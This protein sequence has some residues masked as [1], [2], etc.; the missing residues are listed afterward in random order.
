MLNYMRDSLKHGS[1]PKLVL[2][3]VAIGLVAYLGAY[4]SCE[5][6]PRQGG[7]WA[8]SINGTEIPT[9]LFLTT[10]RNID[11]RYREMFG[12]NYEQF[13]QQAQIGTQAIQMLVERELVLQDA[14]RLGLAV[15][16]EELVERIRG[17]EGLQDP[18]T[19]QFVGKQRYVQAVSRL[20]P[21]GVAAFEQDL[22]NEILMDKW[23]DLVTQT[24]AVSDDELLELYR[25]RTERTAVNYA[26]V[27]SADQ[28]YETELDDTE[29]ARWYD[30]H[31]DDYMRDEGR[32]IRFVVLERQALADRIE[33]TDEEVRASYE[34]NQ[35]NYSHP[36]QRRASHI[37]I[38]TEP[39]AAEEEK[40]RLRRVAEGLMTRALAGEDFAE[41]ARANSQDPGSAERGGDLDFFSRGQMVPP[42]E[43][44]AFNTPVGQIAPLVES[45]FGFHIIKVTDAREAGVTPLD[46]VADQIRRTLRL[47]RA[48]EEVVSEAQR[49]RAELQEAAGLEEVAAREGLEVQ[50]RFLTREDRLTDLGASPEFAQTV[51]DLETGGISPPLRTAPG[52]A[53][54]VVDEIVPASVAPL[55]EIRNS[56]GTDILN[57]RA[58]QAALAAASRALERHGDLAAAARALGEEVKESG[59][60]APGGT[61]PGTGGSTPEMEE[62]L[63][64]PGVMEGDRGV[65]AVPAGALVYEVTARV[66][67]DSLAYEDA[68]ADL[69][70]EL[71]EQRRSA[72]YR[73]VL[74]RMYQQ[75]E[76][77]IN[78]E[79]VEAYNG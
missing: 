61:I 24:V 21:G 77:L 45:D 49:I 7:D 4:F 19:G 73:A 22:R 12:Q 27:A 30:E 53:L 23:T 57:Y 38:R 62:A 34:A 29:V 40:E 64:G 20:H 31:Q 74:E 18:T 58:R 10:A 9:R 72:M 75:Q 25:Q 41:L 28:D 33:I 65:V 55:D 36:E 79:L 69:R 51:F 2:G 63:F 67:F 54:V 6:G 1:W 60:L 43:E 39:G 70:L 48:Q 13:K 16:E 35:A 44:A 52:M 11:Q 15:S 76:V 66:P 50:S 5:S 32:R 47:R 8:A 46:A 68:R 59:D 71:R 3:A 37:L 26:V 56:V 42:F 78:G 14:A 17:I